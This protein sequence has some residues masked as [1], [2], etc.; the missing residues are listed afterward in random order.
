MVFAVRPRDLNV[1]GEERPSAGGDAPDRVSRKYLGGRD[2]YSLDGCN[3]ADDCYSSQ[4]I[5]FLEVCILNTVCEN[6]AELFELEI[7][8]IFNCDIS[9]DRLGLLRDWMRPPEDDGDRA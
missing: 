9:M 6:G 3:D 2:S 4:D 1:A 8:D 7:G 5:F